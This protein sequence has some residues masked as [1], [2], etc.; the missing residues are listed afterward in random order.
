MNITNNIYLY[1]QQNIANELFNSVT[2]SIK[3]AISSYQEELLLKEIETR[4]FIL[5]RISIVPR[6]K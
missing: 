5:L 1:E 6:Q 2:K 4:T 3:K